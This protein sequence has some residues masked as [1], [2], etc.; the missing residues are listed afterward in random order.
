MNH[1]AA[2]EATR[3]ARLLRAFVE[4]ADTL[5]DDYDVTE[6]LHLLAVHCVHLLDAAAAGFMVSDQ[7]GSLQVL[8]SS[9]ERTRLL[10][11]F[12]IQADEG[13]CLDGFRTGET[14]LVPDLAEVTS[15]WPT[16][17][18]RRFGKA[19]ARCTRCPCGC[20]RRPSAR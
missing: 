9:T 13:P 12:Q 7:R 5:V 15:R 8:A 10:E 14:V 17:P 2:S 18:R 19:S 1:P 3:E 16:S 20:A 4:A 6:M 11:L